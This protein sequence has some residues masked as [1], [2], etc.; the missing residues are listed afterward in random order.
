MTSWPVSEWHNKDIVNA[1]MHHQAKASPVCVL[2]WVKAHTRHSS[3]F[4]N[5]RIPWPQSPTTLAQYSKHHPSRQPYCKKRAVVNA[6]MPGFL[7]QRECLNWISL[8]YLFVCILVCRSP[9]QVP[10][11]LSPKTVLGQRDD[12][13]FRAICHWPEK[14]GHIMSAF[15]RSFNR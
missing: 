2:C 9:S 5:L 11:D 7:Y 6:S 15:W 10:G 12:W 3:A 14:D 1:G 13:A 4:K 8:V